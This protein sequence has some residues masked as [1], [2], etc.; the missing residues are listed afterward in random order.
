MQ[1]D[2]QSPERSNPA[3]LADRGPTLDPTAKRTSLHFIA[4][5]CLCMSICFAVGLFA[6]SLH[7]KA[8]DRG[9]AAEFEAEGREEM[10]RLRREL[11]EARSALEKLREATRVDAIELAG[12]DSG[13]PVD[14]AGAKPAPGLR[15]GYGYAGKPLAKGGDTP[16]APRL[17]HPSADDLSEAQLWEVAARHCPTGTPRHSFGMLAT[18]KS[19]AWSETVL[20]VAE[21]QVDESIFS[22]LV[23]FCTRRQFDQGGWAETAP[24][25]V[26]ISG[27]VDMTNFE[28]TAD[29][30][31]EF[32]TS[33]RQMKREG[34]HW[35][36]GRAYFLEKFGDEAFCRTCKLPAP[37]QLLL[38][39]LR[40]IRDEG[41]SE[42]NE[43]I[44]A[45]PDQAPDEPVPAWEV[46]DRVCNRGPF[47]IWHGTVMRVDGKRYEVRIDYFNSLMSRAQ[48]RKG[49]DYDFVDSEIKTF[50][51][52][53]IDSLLKP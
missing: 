27:N 14:L 45:E 49:S 44:R 35:N 24:F 17:A 33:T 16:P 42:L 13:G 23:H 25:S 12:G 8:G 51:N 11:D 34:P 9:G 26:D 5:L 18:L 19:V 20:L 39:E 31:I 28:S 21:E 43:P 3:A 10:A 22:M 2:V 41:P 47:L 38:A 50:Q 32:Y 37:P 6:A 53:S 52:H 29:E 36:E 48:Y 4:A 40:R 15:A 46:G 30:I 7:P 1:C